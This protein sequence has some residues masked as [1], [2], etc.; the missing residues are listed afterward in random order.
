MENISISK[1]LEWDIDTN[2]GESIYHLLN[3]SFSGYPHGRIFFRQ[4]PAFRYLVWQQDELIG[5]CGID[6]R[7]V[8]N[9]GELK[10]IFGLS[11]FC[12]APGHQSSGVGRL[13]L[14][15]IISDSQNSQVEFILSFSGEHAFYRKL[16]FQQYDTLCKWLII[17]N[18]QSFGLVNRKLTDCLFVLPL[19]EDAVW[20]GTFTDLLGSVF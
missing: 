4:Q 1:V 16:G 17:S 11:D 12:I 7:C 3:E 5:H 13:L 15:K 18:D 14:E 10:K 19:K 20:D 6:S 8:Y 9:G 2:I